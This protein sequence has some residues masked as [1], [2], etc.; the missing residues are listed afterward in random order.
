MPITNGM[1]QGR[2]LTLK[3]RRQGGNLDSVALYELEQF[4]L[5]KKRRQKAGV[6]LFK[7]ISNRKRNLGKGV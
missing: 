3:L 7:T 1:I 5:E 2:I 6:W 4:E